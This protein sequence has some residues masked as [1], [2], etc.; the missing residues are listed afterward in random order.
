M[1]LKDIKNNL[2]IAESAIFFYY[3][4]LNIAIYNS[5]RNIKY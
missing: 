5:F 2:V 1:S 4:Y 3:F